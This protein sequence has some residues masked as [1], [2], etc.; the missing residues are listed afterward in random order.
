MRCLG[1][2]W[3][4]VVPRAEDD[5]L[6]VDLA[7]DAREVEVRWSGEEGVEVPQRRDPADDA[8]RPDQE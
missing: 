2:I 8:S 5:G 6:A 1:R 7:D 3:Q 4:R